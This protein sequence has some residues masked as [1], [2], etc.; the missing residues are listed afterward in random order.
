MT[1]EGGLE[2]EPVILRRD[3]SPDESQASPA[4]R[5]GRSAFGVA[6]AFTAL[7]LR[8]PGHG[9]PT[10]SPPRLVSVVLGCLLLPSRLRGQ[11]GT[12]C[13]LLLSFIHHSQLIRNWLCLALSLHH[14]LGGLVGC[15]GCSVGAFDH[16]APLVVSLRPAARPSAPSFTQPVLCPCTHAS[17]PHTEGHLPAHHALR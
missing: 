12:R 1:L 2:G 6:F 10:R 16:S 3:P 8:G 11:W 15:L 7:A 17:S 5:L 13:P 14:L 4:P 9:A